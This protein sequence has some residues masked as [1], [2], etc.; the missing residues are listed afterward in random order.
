[1]ALCDQS[2][3]LLFTFS[4]LL[5]SICL[6]TAPCRADSST[7]SRFIGEEH[8]DARKEEPRKTQD[9]RPE[10]V[11]TD[12][13]AF[14]R[15]T[16][17]SNEVGPMREASTASLESTG[18]DPIGPKRL[19]ETSADETIGGMAEAADDTGGGR[20]STDEEGREGKKE[21]TFDPSAIYQMVKNSVVLIRAEEGLGTGFLVRDRRTVATAFH[22][23]R[24]G[25]E[26]RVQSR[27]GRE[28]AARV[29]RYDQAH[30]LA[31]IGLN[32]PLSAGIP[33]VEA[34]S[35]SAEIGAP[36]VIIGHPFGALAD[37]AGAFKGLLTWTMTTGVIS[38]M[39][40]D[41]IQ[42]DAAINPGNSGG[43]VLDRQGRVL[44]VVSSK[45]RNASNV[46]FAVRG[47]Y[48][49]A[50]LDRREEEAELPRL[51]VRRVGLGL[52]R[53]QAAHDL[54][55]LGVVAVIES[56]PPAD[57]LRRA[58]VLGIRSVDAF[59]PSGELLNYSETFYSAS[60][61]L[62]YFLER[63]DASLNAGLLAGYASVETWSL[64][65]DIGSCSDDMCPV[66]LEPRRDADWRA[67]MLFS[68]RFR[69]M[70]DT[71]DFSAGIVL[72]PF[73]KPLTAW[74][75]TFELL[76]D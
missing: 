31:L 29:L 17:T 28:H 16:W 10:S 33:L 61:E 15:F 68:L 76:N 48:L 63:A 72:L 66:I 37:K 62:G 52:V 53:A 55:S 35:D 19:D 40:D 51:G 75:F 3:I 42:T 8:E 6:W 44:G 4:R 56:L 12:D 14:A 57:G 43:P 25:G 67:G 73:E 49:W 65:A 59:P 58:I 2:R 41:W 13:G 5:F 45:L 39:S 7:L 34:S 9:G 50:L 30:D 47:D 27:D 54:W 64:S 70:F 38:A 20:T 18:A 22:V 69:N 74:R 60:Y 11:P 46:G 21:D 26:V 23:V 71:F 36:V 1:M 32:E 24:D